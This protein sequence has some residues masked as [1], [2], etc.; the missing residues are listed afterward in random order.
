MEIC[1][2]G[3]LK[4]S[5]R[6]VILGGA[7]QVL[8]SLRSL[9]RAATPSKYPRP[10]SRH[11]SPYSKTF[12]RR[13]V[14]CPTSGVRLSLGYRTVSWEWNVVLLKL[15]LRILKEA[16]AIQTGPLQTLR[17]EFTSHK[18]LSSMGFVTILGDF[19]GECAVTPR[20][21]EVLTMYACVPS[22]LRRS[23]S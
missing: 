13:Q 18:S 14:P 16:E 9:G 22:R 17:M 15:I 7:Q 2:S 12:G 19:Q 5:H 3:F 1:Q 20:V 4:G 11:L 21:H 23:R 8:R 10:E 6:S